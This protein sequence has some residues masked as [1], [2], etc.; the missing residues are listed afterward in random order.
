[1]IRPEGTATPLVVYP[2]QGYHQ[3]NQL[4]LQQEFSQGSKS[5]GKPGSALML[6]GQVELQA[7]LALW[8]TSFKL[9]HVHLS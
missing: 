7:V 6:L 9:A 3:T 1:M 8:Q 5:C 4:L 2:T